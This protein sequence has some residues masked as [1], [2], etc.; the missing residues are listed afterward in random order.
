MF[1]INEIT[2]KSVKSLEIRVISLKS[3]DLEISYTIFWSVGPLE[4]ITKWVS[5]SASAKLRIFDNYAIL[6]LEEY[7]SMTL[8]NKIY[9]GFFIVEWFFVRRRSYRL[10]KDNRL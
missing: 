5:A 4:T 3:I 2:L 7:H 6:R 8:I 1:E 10:C 9:T